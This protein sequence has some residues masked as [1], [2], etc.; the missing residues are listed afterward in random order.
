LA[1]AADYLTF[2]N[3]INR[4][5]VQPE[6]YK[7]FNKPVIIYTGHY[8]DLRLDHDLVILLTKSFPDFEILFVGTYVVED[9]EKFGLLS[10]PNLHFIGSRPIEELPAY[11]KYAK[12]AI[13]PYRSNYLTGGIY[14][15]KI[16]EYLAAGIPCVSMNFSKDIAGFSEYIYL[17]NSH[18]EFVEKV[19]EALQEN[20]QENLAKRMAFASDNSWRKRIE[21]L[22]ALVLQFRRG[23]K[24]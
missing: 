24:V 6:E 3:A 21:K 9:L 16:N 23:E 12:V 20:P 18:S 14:P 22:E 7:Q 15:L 10:I 19:K 13:I 1:N 8:S 17:A 4:D 5:L 11:L 2:E